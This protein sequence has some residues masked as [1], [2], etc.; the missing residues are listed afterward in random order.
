MKNPLIL[1]TAFLF[2]FA[3]CGLIGDAPKEKGQIVSNDAYPDLTTNKDNDNKRFAIV[4]YPFIDGDISVRPM[5]GETSYPS[6]NFHTEPN[7]KGSVISF[8]PIKPGEGPNSFH[9]PANFTMADVVFYDNEGKPLK[10]TDKMQVSFT[11]DLQTDRPRLKLGDRM[12]YYYSTKS[13]RID[14]AP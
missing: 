2:L 3:S 12:T 14:K 6:I 5:G 1:P 4:G 9:T 10:S 11:L 13:V 8:F 7:G